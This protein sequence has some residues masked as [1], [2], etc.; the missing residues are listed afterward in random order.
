MHFTKKKS[1]K[2]KVEVPTFLT[3]SEHVTIYTQKLAT[4]AAGKKRKISQR[5]AGTV[6]P[7]IHH[8]DTW[9]GVKVC[10]EFVALKDARCMF[11]ALTLV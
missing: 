8:R 6:C 9:Q 4:K 5:S 7:Q 2:R 1:P 10:V 3:H 11:A